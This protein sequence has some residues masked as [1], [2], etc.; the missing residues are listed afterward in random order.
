MAEEQKSKS[1]NGE[2]KMLEVTS[3]K[4]VLETCVVDLFGIKIDAMK[5]NENAAKN[6]ESCSVEIRRCVQLV[7]AST[8][9]VDALKNCQVGD[10]RLCQ[11]G[12]PCRVSF[13]GGYFVGGKIGCE[14]GCGQVR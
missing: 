11:A 5:K 2:A 1:H 14:Q 8:E 9:T 4:K 13:D 7:T 12:G 10:G 6:N 3:Q